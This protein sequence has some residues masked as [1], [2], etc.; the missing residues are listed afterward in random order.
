VREDNVINTIIVSWSSALPLPQTAL[1]NNIM[2]YFV[3]MDSVGFLVPS[4]LILTNTVVAIDSNMRVNYE[5]LLLIIASFKLNKSTK[6]YCTST[7][8]GADQEYDLTLRS[9]STSSIDRTQVLVTDINIIFSHQCDNDR[10]YSMTSFL[11]HDESA[12]I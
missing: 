6:N 9:R 2:V 7:Y 11:Q 8:S 10:H 4:A 5:D 1:V 12:C 3:T